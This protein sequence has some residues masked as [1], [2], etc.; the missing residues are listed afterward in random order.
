M[1]Q[2]LSGSLGAATFNGVNVC[3]TSWECDDTAN[4]IDVTSTCSQ[5]FVEFIPGL[6]SLTGTISGNYDLDAAPSTVGLS[7]GSKLTNVRLY[8]SKTTSSSAASAIG[9]APSEAYISLGAIY[10]ES[11]KY[12]VEVASQITW[13][14]S[15]KSTGSYTGI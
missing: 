15:F 13:T 11:I 6:S 9:L 10:I 14:A 1:A 4:L 12:N 3:I 7:K 2:Y 8:F 5:G